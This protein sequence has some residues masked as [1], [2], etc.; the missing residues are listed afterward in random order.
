MKD[1]VR[2]QWQRQPAEGGSMPLEEIRTQAVLFQKR[3][4][5]R[6]VREYSAMALSIVMGIVLFPFFRPFPL[7][8]VALGLCVAGTLVIAFQFRKRMSTRSFTA[9]AASMS[10]REFYLRELERQRDA[11]LSIW[12]WYILPML[13]GA[14]MLCLAISRLPGFG[15]RVGW[16]Y[17][18]LFAIAFIV[19]GKLNQRK[20]RQLQTKINELRE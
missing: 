2:R 1:D 4:R 7:V 12:S 16:T 5:K 9:A 18:V 10:C 13:P 3:L 17:A 6:N 20:A 11:N 15:P 19:V 8:G 14:A